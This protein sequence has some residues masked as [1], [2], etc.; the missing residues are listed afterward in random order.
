MKIVIIGGGV[1]GEAILKGLVAKG[2]AKAGDITVTDVSPQ[3]R[4]VLEQKYG[5]KASA[6]NSASLSAAEVVVLAIKPQHLAGVMAELKGHLKAK[7][8]ALSIVAGA[9]LSTLRKGSGFSSL[10]RAMPNTPAQIGEGITLW[11]ATAEVNPSQKEAVRLILGALGKELSVSDEKYIDMATAVSGSGPA[12]IFLIIEGLIDAAVHIG[13]PRD[14]AVEMVLQTV[15]GSVMLAQETGKHPA[16][17]KNMVTSPGGTTVE[18]LHKLEA[19]GLRALLTHA[20]L[21]A[22]DK[23]QA[24]GKGAK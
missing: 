3:R 24:L 5:V 18:G 13:L 21:A 9:T 22:Y 17:L 12:Y 1:M 7:Q 23:A 2:V 4:Q 11:T 10:V 19:G 15:R 16:E 20:V 14:M 6:D 8:V